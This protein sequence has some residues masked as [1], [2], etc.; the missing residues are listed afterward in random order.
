VA[1]APSVQ[2]R[3]A[4]VPEAPLV[5]A[6]RV[7]RRLESE[8]VEAVAHPVAESTMQ[9]AAPGARAAP[10]ALAAGAAAEAQATAALPTASAP[11]E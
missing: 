11:P 9:R 7:V 8:R 1:A 3:S 2:I 10:D 5:R 6:V 4:S